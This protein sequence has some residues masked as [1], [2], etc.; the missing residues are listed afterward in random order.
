MTPEVSV[1]IPAFNRW[2]ALRET[3]DA[4]ARSDYPRGRWEAVV[5]DDGSREDL[6][7]PLA[8]WAAA[9]GA[10]VRGIRQENQ[11]PAAAR[12]RGAAEARGRCLLFIDNDILVSP[13]FIRAHVETLAAHS[14]CWI[15]GRITHPEPLRATPFGRYRD[16]CW[17]QFHNAHPPDRISETQGGS[18]A[19]LS[20]P[21]ADFRRLGGFDTE[22]TIASSEDWDL[23]MRARLAGLRVLYHPHIIGLHNDWAVTLERFCERQRLYSISDVLLCRKYGEASPR[24]ALLRQNGPAALGRECPLVT[25]RK[26]LKGALATAPG[27]ALVR[28]GCAVAERAAPDSSLCRRAYSLAVAVA[29]FRGVREGLRRYGAPDGA[30]AGQSGQP[31]PAG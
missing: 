27:R 16:W 9:S 24:Q 10:P 6:L 31:A 28:A 4:L 14:G 23:L 17:E 25:M 2:D 8:E 7:T 1:I 19:N 26:L 29:M 3:L 30:G 15:A 5:V 20:L 22:F 12:N 18:A 21:A 13:G 11:G